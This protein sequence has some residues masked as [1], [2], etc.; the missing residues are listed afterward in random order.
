ML[1]SWSIAC[2]NISTIPTNTC[3]NR[4]GII[5][6]T[7]ICHGLIPIFSA[8]FIKWLS[9]NWSTSPRINR[10]KEVQWVRIMPVA[11]PFKPFP[12]AKEIRIRSRIWGIPMTR[13]IKPL[14]RLSAHFPPAAQ[15][16][17]IP[18]AIREL[19]ADVIR[20]MRILKDKPVRVRTNISRPIQSVPK[21]YCIQGAIFFLVKSVVSACSFRQTPATSTAPITNT[22]S[23]ISAVISTRLLLIPSVRFKYFSKLSLPFI[24]HFQGFAILFCVSSHSG[25]YDL[26]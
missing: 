13:S 10:A 6:L 24:P 25:V 20:P 5:C 17:P 26:I 7:P 4:W 15:A 19:K 23:A 21:G 2:G 3:G 16:S 1:A 18:T 14:I 22:A 9:F 11:T 12:N 8:I